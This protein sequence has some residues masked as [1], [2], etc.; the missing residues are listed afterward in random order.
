MCIGKDDMNADRLTF[1]NSERLTGMARF[2][3]LK[4]R[5]LQSADH[6]KADH[7]LVFHDDDDDNAGRRHWGH[8]SKPVWSNSGFPKSANQRFGRRLGNEAALGQRS[9]VAHIPTVATA[10]TALDRSRRGHSRSP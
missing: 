2:D 4:I 8:G 3:Y 9:L 1:Q 10:T 5:R 6:R 7:Y